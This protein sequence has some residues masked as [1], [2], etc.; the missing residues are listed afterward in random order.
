MRGRAWSGSGPAWADTS[1]SDRPDCTA[2][3]KSSACRFKAVNRTALSMMMV[4]D[5]IEAA[6][7]PIMTVFT[8]QS[9]VMNS[10]TGFIIE[11]ST[12]M[13]IQALRADSGSVTSSST[14]PT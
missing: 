3:S 8:T 14:Q 4:H 7:R 11:A 2:F 10:S 12:G 13:V 6:A 1:S 9:A 5:Q